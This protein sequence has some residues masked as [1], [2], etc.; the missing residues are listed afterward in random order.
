M[1]I[2]EYDY[3]GTNPPLLDVSADTREQRPYFTS[4]RSVRV[5]RKA[6][7][8]G[9]YSIPG[10]EHAVC[11]ERK[12]LDDYVCSVM[13]RDRFQ[14]ELERMQAM[15]AA[16]I[17]V[18]SDISALRHGSHHGECPSL[19][20]IER[21]L[22][23]QLRFGIPTIWAG[24]RSGGQIVTEHVLRQFLAVRNDPTRSV[25]VCDP[26]FPTTKGACL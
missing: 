17:V 20:V 9:D 10:F 19:Y 7:K 8:T 14:R 2:P 1:T 15:S 23:I 25:C 5:T 4:H 22:E 18:E 24:N 16:C 11:V 26:R 6:L 21:M 13:H 12:T 3:S